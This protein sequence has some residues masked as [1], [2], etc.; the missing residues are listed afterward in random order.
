[1]QGNIKNT[2]GRILSMKKAVI[3]TAERYPTGGAGAVRLQYIARALKGAGF[4]VVVLCRGNANESGVEEEVRYF[5]LRKP[6]SYKLAKIYDYFR[7][8][9]RVKRLLQTEF[10]DASCLYLY[11]VPAPLAKWIKSRFGKET[12][13]VYD[14]VEWYSPEEF[15]WGRLDIRYQANNYINSRLIES[16]FSVVAISRYF[17]DYYRQK[18]LPVLR[19]PILCDPKQAKKKL[20]ISE[21]LVLF[22]AGVPEKK[23]RIGNVL[24]A[25]LL[26]SPEDR[27]KLKVRFIGVTQESLARRSGISLRTIEACSDFLELSGRMPRSAVLDELRSADFLVLPRDASLRY[28]KAGFPSKVVES[29]ANATPVLCN[30]SSDLELYLT[31]GENALIADDHTPEALAATLRRALC[32]TAAEKERMSENALRT[33]ERFFDYRLYVEPLQEFING[34][35]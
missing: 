16:P 30:Y 29:L 2:K 18:E 1:M 17:E 34:D 25:A 15:N 7:F 31:D 10:K 20:K 32:L 4:E 5:S 6:R 12:K 19:V 33:A 26:L 21:R 22:Y 9:P 3:I 23:D 14:C 28:A 27:K 35:G 11:G 13:L 24:E 8:I